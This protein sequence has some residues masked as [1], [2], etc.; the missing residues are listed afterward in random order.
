MTIKVLHICE[1]AIGGVATYLN[2]LAALPPNVAAQRFLVPSFHADSLNKTLE[3]K[4]FPARR[5]GFAALW[6]LVLALRR[7][8]VQDAPDLMFFHSTFSLFAL[9]ALR[10]SGNRSPA[11]YC[12]HGWAAARYNAQSLKGALV[13]HIEGRLCGLADMV[14]NV[15]HADA[16]HAANW[17]YRGQQTV[18]ENAVSDC[19]T[20]ARSDLFADDAGALHLLFVGRFD[21]QKGLD[22]LL[23][24]FEK[25]RLRRNDLRLHIVG[26]SVRADGGEI[27]LPQGASLSGWVNP[28]RIDDWYR[29]ADLLVVPSR[30]E[31]L[32]LVIPEAYRN[33]TPVCVSGQ[34]AMPS[35]VAVEETG[36]VFQLDADAL[37]DRLATLD[38]AAL[39]AMRGGARATFERRFSAPRFYAQT[40]ALWKKLTE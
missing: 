4:V 25:A 38:R 11:I 1:T 6:Q 9:L 34:S 14:V 36:Y 17:G 39:R 21:R 23:E 27:T 29:S 5:R 18:I 19:A 7:S 12:P 3:I 26:A 30:W 2:L 32:P 31:G 13:R 33:G 22:I 24:A 40:T 8:V 35:L 37:A 20:D 28:A 15:S 10:L 16:D